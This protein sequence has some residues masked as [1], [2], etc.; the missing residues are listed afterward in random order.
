[1]SISNGYVS[2]AE[3]KRQLDIHTTDS[4]DDRELERIIEATSRIIDEHCQRRFYQVTETRVFT[5]TDRECPIDD[6]VSLTAVETDD[7]AD[8]YAD[9]TWTDRDYV[10]EPANA[11]SYLRPYST[12]AMSLW[13]RRAFP[14]NIPRA[15][16]LTGV[17]GWPSV[18]EAVKTACLI[19]VG[20]VFRSKDAPFGII[21]STETGVVRMNNRLH[22]EAQLLLEPY[23]RRRGLAV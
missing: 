10:L 20:L 11:P 16:H 9:S 2:L 18:P 21:G 1:M 13:G 19:Q 12:I 6:L 23:R 4:T 14:Y 5:A 22:P 17:W 7:N 3:A 15:L 8:G